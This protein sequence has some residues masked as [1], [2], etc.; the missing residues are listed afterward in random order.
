M[1]PK[2]NRRAVLLLLTVAGAR[3]VRSEEPF[4]AAT[5]LTL[6]KG[7]WHLN[8]KPTYPGAKAEGLLLNVRMANAVFEDRNPATCPKGFDPEKNSAAFIEKVPQ[9]VAQGV[10][11]FTVGLQGGSPGYRGGLCSAYEADGSLR[12]DFL[13]R[14]ARVIEGCDRAGAAVILTC[15]DEEED[16]VLKDEEAVKRAVAG[17]ARWIK[18]RGYQNVVLEIAHEH[19]RKG[20]QHASIREPAGVVGLIRLAR[21][22]APGLLVSTSGGAGGRLDHQIQNAADFLLLHLSAVPVEEIV[23]RVATADKVSKAI[24]CNEDRRTGEEGAAALEAAVGA[25]ASWGYSNQKKNQSYPFHFEGADDDPVV[26]ARFKE[27]TSPRR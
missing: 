8:G 23:E 15:F 7:L 6:Q 17:T 14:V 21:E 22:T 26:Y 27:L 4:Q 11:G 20:Y 16:Q 2:L 12:P 24:V 13:K 9:Y 19:L 3:A 1:D 5:R 18:E 25:L 10:R